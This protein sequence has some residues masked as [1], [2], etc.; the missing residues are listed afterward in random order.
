MSA[1][2]CEESTKAEE[3][4]GQTCPLMRL[5]KFGTVIAIFRV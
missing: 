2:A 1:E 4:C 3:C 5:V